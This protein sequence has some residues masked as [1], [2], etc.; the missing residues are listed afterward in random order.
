MAGEDEAPFHLYAPVVACKAVCVMYL[1]LDLGG[2]KRWRF[3]C[4]VISQWGL[5]GCVE[6]VVLHGVLSSWLCATA[7]IS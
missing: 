3:Q 7:G 5:H 6:V 2:Q 1:E 4:T